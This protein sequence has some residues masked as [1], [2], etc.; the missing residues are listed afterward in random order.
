MEPIVDTPIKL[1]RELRS[2]LAEIGVAWNK[3]KPVVPDWVDTAF[4]SRAG[5]IELKAF[6]SRNIGLQFTS[7]GR[8]APK[9]LPKAFFKTKFGTLT[10]N[11]VAARGMATACAQLV[12]TATKQ[13]Y[14]RLGSDVQAIRQQ[15]L[16]STNKS[17]IDLDLLLSF[18]W[19]HGIPILYLPTLP[20]TGQKMEGMVT[21]ISGR[22]VIILTKKVHHPDWLL[23]IL[24]H[25]I[26]HLACGHLPEDEG[27]A[28][29]D[30]AIELKPDTELDL[31]E[32]EANDFAKHLLAPDGKEIS[33]GKLPVAE[34]FADLAMR[35]GADNHM[36]P[37]YV[38][39]NSVHNTRINGKKPF[40]LGQ[41]ALKLL[42]SN[43]EL[44]AAELCKLALHEN[45]KL[46][47][48]RNDSID[49]LEKLEL[50]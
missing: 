17:W 35:Y 46:E 4:L 18:C 39:L 24:S 37:G 42:S 12:A 36:A 47:H 44:N 26:G 10:E 40:A 27:E 2:E 9:N 28:I 8:L 33:I 25:E 21:Y 20:V 7:D 38:I 3:L 11:I 41:A 49:F 32:R 14:V 29:V 6:L 5:V 1:E 43:G 45:I 30:D 13:P 23:F 19:G 50:L 31:K 48:L 16:K 15:I 34:K 22:P